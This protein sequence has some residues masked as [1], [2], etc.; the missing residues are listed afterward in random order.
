[1]VSTTKPQELT[2]QD[3]NGAIIQTYG[4]L[5]DANRAHDDMR[6]DMLDRSLQELQRERDAR[7]RADV[8]VI[9]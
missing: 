6:Y 3:L 8:T 5:M 9:V 1:M 2:D 7:H 4:L